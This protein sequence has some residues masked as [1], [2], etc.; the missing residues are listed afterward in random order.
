[1]MVVV[2]VVVVEVVAVATR[3]EEEGLAELT[4]TAKLELIP[5]WL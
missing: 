5:E 3:D 2:V 1:M 4:P